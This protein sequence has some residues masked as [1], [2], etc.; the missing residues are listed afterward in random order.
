MK[1]LL[2]SFSATM[3]DCCNLYE[4]AHR[5]NLYTECALRTTAF[6]E[7]VRDSEYLK[8]QNSQIKD[9][10]LRTLRFVTQYPDRVIL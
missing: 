10:A 3:S 7:S 6:L 5:L 8:T 9:W 2:E 4:K 1:A